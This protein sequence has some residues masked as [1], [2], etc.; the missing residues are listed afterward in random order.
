MQGSE[1]DEKETKRHR[2]RRHK[3]KR[4]IHDDVIS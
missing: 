2:H 3:I 4:P 1:N